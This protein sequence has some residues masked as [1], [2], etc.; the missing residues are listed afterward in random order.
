MPSISRLCYV[1]NVLVAA[2]LLVASVSLL[3]TDQGRQFAVAL[4]SAQQLQNLR[5]QQGTQLQQGRPAR[6][7][8]PLVLLA[9][10]ITVNDRTVHIS[11]PESV[12]AQR[13]EESRQQQ[14]TQRFHAQVPSTINLTAARNFWAATC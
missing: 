4:G 11:R 13:Q 10:Q 14:A 9:H 5:L 8:G 6:I 1:P 3:A 2:L 12:M 7:G